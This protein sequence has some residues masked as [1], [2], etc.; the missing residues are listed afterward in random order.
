MENN[1][2]TTNNEKEKS[3]FYLVPITYI[4]KALMKIWSFLPSTVSFGFNCNLYLN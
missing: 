1:N 4:K 3:N 2:I